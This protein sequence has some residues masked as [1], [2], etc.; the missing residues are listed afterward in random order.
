MSETFAFKAEI[1]QLLALIINAI[2]SNKDVFL[3][4]LISNASDAINKIRHK[5]LVE[6][7]HVLGDNTEFMIRIDP[8]KE[9]NTL[10]IQDNGVGMTKDELVQNLGT[11]AHSGTKEFIKALGEGKTDLSLIGQFGMGFYSAYLV[12]DKVI[13]ISKSNASDEQYRWESDAS[14]SFTVC[15]DDSESIGRG[16]KIIMHIKDECKEYLEEH[17]L[18]NII[19]K[20]SQFVNYPIELAVERKEEGEDNEEQ[21]KNE[22]ITE[23][24]E[25]NIEESV[26]DEKSTQN[27]V[28]IVRREWKHMNHQKPLWTRHSDEISKE[29]YGDFYKTVFND[30]EEH[31]A[32]KHVS[33]E[34]SVMYKSLLFVPK[35]A[36]Y[37]FVQL[38]KKQN[39]MHL[40]VRHVF[41]TD[42]SEQFCP[43]YLNFV[44]GI[45]DTD[46]LPLNI[47]R[48]MLQ[49][50]TMIRLIKT[51]ITKKCIE[52]FN[53]IAKDKDEYK[54]F[55]ATYNR[56]IKIGVHEDNTNRDRLMELL[57]F[58]STKSGDEM[59]SLSE[60][61]ER[62]PDTQTNI[63]YI[64]GESKTAVE[65]SPFLE[66]LRKKG[67]EVLYF[68][69]AVDEYMIQT[70]QYYKGKQFKCC[71]KG[72]FKIEDDGDTE[73]LKQLE[74]EYKSVCAYVKS[75]LGAKVKD[76]K[77]SS[78]LEESP[79]II[80]TSEYGYTANMQRII[81]AQTIQN[82]DMLQ[83]IGNDKTL[84]INVNHPIVQELKMRVENVTDTTQ[85]VT[86]SL[87]KLIFNTS[88]IN[89]G[90]SL[91]NPNTY[92][93]TIFKMIQTNLSLS[94]D[95]DEDTQKEMDTQNINDV[96]MEEVD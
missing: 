19:L 38:D 54:K 10:T 49:Q 64:S 32:M 12:A 42:D 96:K 62:M 77:V 66:K 95:T 73:Q 51:S 60:Y 61:V 80:T 84:E 35:H 39:N 4:E 44:K 23:D 28:E 93:D 81:K 63:Y 15:K 56:N 8:N 71:T 24:T 46:D 50:N 21:T 92:C 13:V 33:A 68:V 58:Y 76:V 43:P 57:R 29:E 70:V 87:V 69:D 40:Y 17:K 30:W 41:I 55:Y 65:N 5:S 75:V 74:D 48:E 85:K 45:I 9:A 37:D 86:D 52:L 83:N 3:R 79:C 53:D 90:F 36:P 34:G 22:D 20:H 91:D 14:G 2:Y 11:I 88:L 31:L 78:R 59:V 1:N 94:T 26:S 27:K 18:E 25:G 82:T 16:T 47:S 72:D 89:S 7:A 67:Y 6:G